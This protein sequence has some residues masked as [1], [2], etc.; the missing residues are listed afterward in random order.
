MTNLF[1]YYTDSNNPIRFPGA[2]FLLSSVLVAVSLFFAVRSL[3][4]QA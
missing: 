3:K 4:K 1:A 2:P